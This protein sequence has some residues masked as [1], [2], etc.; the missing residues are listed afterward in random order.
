MIR[1]A[2]TL[3]LAAALG[4][5]APTAASA[6]TQIEFGLP[7]AA[8]WLSLPS[9]AYRPAP[10]GVVI[11]LPDAV[12]HD[13]RSASYVEL[14]LRHGFATLELS[15]D[16]G[17][18]A[19]DSLSAAA[20]A[21]RQKLASDR[22]FGGKVAM[23]GFGEGGRAALAWAG[24]LP[25]VALYPRCAAVETTAP[26]EAQPDRAP[27]LLLYPATDATDRP[28]ACARLAEEL[29]TGV[30]RHAY[31]DTTPGWDIPPVGAIAGPTL[32][33]RDAATFAGE[34]SLRYSAQPRPAAT[35]DAAR[36]VAWFLSAAANGA[37]PWMPPAGDP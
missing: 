27:V 19:P 3:T 8:G 28:G 6:Q 29:G 25:V 21:A 9:A 13:G 10:N 26:T 30:F 12:G 16:G 1:H 36:R 14:L 17:D 11:V 33:P 2:A 24:V 32:Q 20:T 7:Q 31:A 18:A 4:L 5:A 37:G 35:H 15:A 23:L 22:R 34:A